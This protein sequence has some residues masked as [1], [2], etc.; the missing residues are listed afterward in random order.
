MHITSTQQKSG[1]SEY[2]LNHLS[3]PETLLKTA[4]SF[5]DDLSLGAEGT[6][7]ESCCTFKNV[8]FLFVST[9]YIV[10]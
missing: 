4:N 10:I 8:F 9:S 6:E 5:E 1:V 3:F 7:N 2:L